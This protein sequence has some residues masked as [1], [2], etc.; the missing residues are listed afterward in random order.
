[1]RRADRLFEILQ[2]LRGG[3]LRTARELAAL[4]EVS[5]RTV[6][7]DVA[8]LQAQGVPIDGERGVGYVLRDDFFLPPLA[9]NRE[10]A[11]AL[12][13]GTNLVVAFGDF[14]LAQAARE[15]QIKI[16]AVSSGRQALAPP[17]LTA[18]AS[19]TAVAAQPFL[20]TIRNAIRDR[21]KLAVTYCDLDGRETYRIVRPLNLEFWGQVWTLTTWCEAREDFRVFRCDR[22]KECWDQNE[23]FRAEPGRRYADFLAQILEAKA[24][25][26]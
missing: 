17:G 6:W 23:R 8:A 12:M 25:A 22:F 14:G 7:R 21:R 11:E 19:D 15:L 3:R 10:E 26:R 18:V 20:M 9:L 2:L 5:T 1:M 13:W 4:L 24:G 16:A